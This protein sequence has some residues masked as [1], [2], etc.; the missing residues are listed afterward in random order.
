MKN[1]I[2][3]ITVFVMLTLLTF[4][5]LNLFSSKDIEINKIIY[6]AKYE[7]THYYPGDGWNSNSCTGSGKCTKDF[8]TDSQGW[9][10][11]NQ[12][13][14]DY[15]VVAAATVYCRDSANHCGISSKRGIAQSIKYYHYGDILKLPINGKM[16]DAMVLDSCGACMWASQDTH[17]MEKIDIFVQNPNAKKPDGTGQTDNENETNENED[18]GINYENHVTSFGGDINKGWILYRLKNREEYKTFD[19][20]IDEN[21][22]DGMIDEIFKRAEISYGGY[23]DYLKNNNVYFDPAEAGPYTSWLQTNSAWGGIHLGDSKYTMSSSGCAVTSVAIQFA[24]MG[25]DVTPGSL[26]QYL[27]THGGF[28]DGG[29]GALKWNVATQNVQNVNYKNAD[30]IYNNAGS[31]TNLKLS[32][33]GE[34]L[35]EGNNYIIVHINGGRTDNHWVAVTGVTENDLKIIDPGGFSSSDR[36]SFDTTFGLQNLDAK[37]IRIYTKN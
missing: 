23:I 31:D 27:N 37:N 36:T 11:Y 4:S 9:Y 3:L 28:E 34:L 17:G 2:M 26:V 16:Y 35:K 18:V 25:F 10:Y 32:R 21:D 14:K 13:G 7:Y 29:T 24:R 8:T 19:S 15:L 33:I 6:E 1:N 22:V 12:G 20:E 5:F 30:A